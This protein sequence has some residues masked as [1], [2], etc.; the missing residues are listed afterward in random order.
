M[1]NNNMVDNKVAERKL[2]LRKNL[3][4][5]RG[6]LERV[7]SECQVSFT[8]NY[9]EYVKILNEEFSDIQ[10]QKMTAKIKRE[11]AQ[12]IHENLLGKWADIAIKAYDAKDLH[13]LFTTI[14]FLVNLEPV[15]AYLQY[16]NHFSI[17]EGLNNESKASETLQY[18]SDTCVTYTTEDIINYYTELTRTKYKDVVLGAIMEGV[19]KQE[20]KEYSDYISSYFVEVAR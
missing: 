20:Q 16:S 14:V 4:K 11:V 2:S 8:K 6:V 17:L 15:E 19:K 7:C 18:I 10:V 12:I 13:D 3:K 9:P 1:K 5:A